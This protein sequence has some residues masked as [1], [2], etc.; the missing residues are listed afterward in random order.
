MTSGS[1]QMRELKILAGLLAGF[2]ILYFLPVESARFQQSLQSAV[3]LMRW[4]AREHVLLC[5][6]PAFFIAGGIGVFVRQAAVMKYLGPRAPKILAYGVA[7]VSGTLLAVCSC[8]V[9]PMFGGIYMRGAGLG[10]AI[11]FL[12][13]GPAINVLAIA[14]TARILGWELGA[15][16]AIG[17]ISFSVVIGLLM[18]LIFL[19]EE[20]A[21]A[22]QPQEVYLGDDDGGGRPL[23]QVGLFFLSMA[24]ILVFANWGRPT[25]PA[26]VWFALYQ[27]KWLLTS[28][29]AVLLGFCLW[30][31]FQIRLA[32]IALAA[33][34]TAALG[35]AF[36]GRP[37]IAVA[38]GSAGLAMLTFTSGAQ[39][40]DWRD[41]SWGFAK[42]ILPL[43]FWGV[44][45]A[46]F[47]FG[48]PE[49]SDAGIVPH[50]WVKALVGETPDALYTMLGW[51]EGASIQWLDTLWPL[52]TNFFASF[53]GA[54]MYFATLTEVPILRGLLDGGMGQ[55]PALALLL[56]G[57]ALSL[58]STLVI[59]SILGPRK[60]VTYVGLVV[61]MS[62][63]TGML[64]GAIVR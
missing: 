45:A 50:A 38:A 31:F 28:A 19:K 5:L 55:G 42:Q 24:G 64:F 7:S 60:T 1:S 16:R 12:Y 20:R 11:A 59:H 33:L 49:Q 52:W 26:G 32:W 40:K 62:T 27:A 8:T 3:R 10:P 22:A 23:W 48:S 37:V 15:A 6:T 34:P 25:E 46:G 58:P 43:L 2:L 36:P 63:L 21:K 39:I 53:A 13:S 61:I 57:P 56:A 4:Y 35:F 47:F 44:L 14:L 54:L 41:Q 29:F 17:A 9:L 18:H 30:R 51:P